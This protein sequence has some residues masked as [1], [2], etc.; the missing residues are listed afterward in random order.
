MDQYLASREGKLSERTLTQ[1]RL[2][3][4]RLISFCNSKNAT[5]M[6][7]LTIDLLSDLSWTVCQ[8]A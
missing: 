3:L 1:H 8:Q 5:Y 7:D 6:G 2:V 4:D